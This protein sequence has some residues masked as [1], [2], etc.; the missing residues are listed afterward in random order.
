MKIYEKYLTE[1]MK[2]YRFRVEN[3]KGQRKVIT[4]PA[5]DPA[6]VIKKL[7]E[8]GWIVQNHYEV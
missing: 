3:L 4:M 1:G 6:N 2:K 7:A 5:S 8:K